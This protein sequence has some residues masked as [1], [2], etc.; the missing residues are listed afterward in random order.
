MMCTMAKFCSRYELAAESAAGLLYGSRSIHPD[1]FLH[2]QEA[3]GAARLRPQSANKECSV[4][5]D[6]RL[7]VFQV[8]RIKRLTNNNG[9]THFTKYMGSISKLEFT[10][11]T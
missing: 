7:L 3:P 8:V 6:A 1:A 5:L 11:L 2:R 9:Q 10:K 4:I